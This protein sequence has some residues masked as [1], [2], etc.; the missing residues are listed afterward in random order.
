MRTD[1]LE[2]DLPEELIAQHPA[3]RRPQSRLL[4]LHRADGRLEDRHFCDLPEYLQPGDCL[5][6]N[7]TKV[8]PAR[9]FCRKQTGARIEGLFLEETP[10]GSW[11]VLLKNARNLKPGSRLTFLDRQGREWETLQIQEKLE[12]GQWLL[13]PDTQ[14]PPQAV[15]EHIGSA[16]LPPYIRR[17]AFR[18]EPQED[19]A[20]YQTV[21]ACR[22]G[23]VAAP[24]AGLHFDRPLL[25]QLEQ[26]GIRI[27]CLTLHV[28][29]GTF[30]PVQTETL[31]EHTMH[32]ERYEISPQAAQQINAAAEEGRRII[33]VGTTCVRTLETVAEN[34]RVRPAAGQTALFIQPGYS[35]KIVDALITNFHLPRS[36]LLALTAAFAGLET[37]LSAYRRAVQLRYRFY[38]YGDAMLIL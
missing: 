31:E 5:V 25:Q 15:L 20:R 34:R 32:S 10:D 27:A 17:P 2:Y 19:L 36:T 8:L 30:R 23:A 4:V 11:K 29:I 9:F 1:Q 16:P 6:L 24:T 26:K 13:R 18:Q 38:S 37:I 12:E 22:P 14:K 3:Q 7:D 33:A 21:Y 28:G 35:F